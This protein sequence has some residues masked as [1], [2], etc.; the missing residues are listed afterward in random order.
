VLH[1]EN[2]IIIA[3]GGGHFKKVMSD[4][5]LV[6]K[7]SMSLTRHLSLVTLLSAPMKQQH[8]KAAVSGP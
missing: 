7:G 6:T 2:F 8:S 1:T 3:F 5:R 4:Q